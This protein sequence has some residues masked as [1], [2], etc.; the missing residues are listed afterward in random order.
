MTEPLKFEK[1]KHYRSRCGE[2]WL[3]VFIQRNGDALLVNTKTERTQYCRSDGVSIHCG[4]AN[5]IEAE[6]RNPRQW[7][8]Y[9]YERQDKTCAA[10]L[11]GPAHVSP[12]MTLLARVTVTEGEGL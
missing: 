2:Q 10:V 9:I 4:N 1:D 11:V 3:C 7:T 5:D 8:V 12:N 6:W